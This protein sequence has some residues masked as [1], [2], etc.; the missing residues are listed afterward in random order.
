MKNFHNFRPVGPNKSKNSFV[1]DKNSL[2]KWTQNIKQNS[3]QPELN[4]NLRSP[5]RWKNPLNVWISEKRKNKWP[6]NKSNIFIL[7]R[8]AEAH[9]IQQQ[10]MEMEKKEKEMF[11]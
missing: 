4:S 2:L 10:I 8:Y 6:N 5:T 11:H 7:F 3:P 9:L 1:T